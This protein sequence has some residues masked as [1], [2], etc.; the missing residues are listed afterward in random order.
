MATNTPRECINT[1]WKSLKDD[2]SSSFEHYFTV[3]PTAFIMQ[4]TNMLPATLTMLL[5]LVAAAPTTVNQR[6]SAVIFTAESSINDCGN[7][8]FENESSGA[9]PTVSDCRQIAAN[10]AGGGTWEVENLAG[11]QHQLVQYG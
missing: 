1:V 5:T 2:I 10:I 11:E 4:F 8:S 6:S 3:N 9:S 7:S